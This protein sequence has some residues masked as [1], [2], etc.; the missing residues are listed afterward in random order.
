VAIQRQARLPIEDGDDS[1]AGDR[2]TED[3]F[4]LDEQRN[5]QCTTRPA[6]ASDDAILYE[7]GVAGV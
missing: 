4:A 2:G 3:L 6:D 1:V 5:L 7:T